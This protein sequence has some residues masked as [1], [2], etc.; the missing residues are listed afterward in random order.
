MEILDLYKKEKIIVAAKGDWKVWWHAA[1]GYIFLAI[2]ALSRGLSKLLGLVGKGPV[3]DRGAEWFE[4]FHTVLGDVV[5]MPKKS[6]EVFLA[7][8]IRY[9]GTL[10]HERQHVLDRRQR[11]VFFTLSYLLSREWRGYW[12]YRGYTHNLVIT[13]EKYSRVF[14]EIFENILKNFGK[15]IYYINDKHR[16]HRLTGLLNAVENGKFEGVGPWDNW[17]EVW[18][19]INS[20]LK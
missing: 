15:S 16:L 9:E 1:V 18:E 17:D 12:E 3:T 4:N 5:Y 8:P 10:R 14:P 13:K 2:S 20:E 7:H 6:Y 19:E 11:P